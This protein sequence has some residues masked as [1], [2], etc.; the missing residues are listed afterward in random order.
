MTSAFIYAIVI[1][2]SDLVSGFLFLQCKS[3]SPDRSELFHRHV[4]RDDVGSPHAAEPWKCTDALG[5]PALQ[6]Q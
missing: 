5:S 4:G 2:V 3:H 1:G 6:L